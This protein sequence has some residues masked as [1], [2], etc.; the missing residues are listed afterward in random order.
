[1]KSW[2]ADRRERVL[3]RLAGLAGLLSTGLWFASMV[4]GHIVSGTRS[5]GVSDASVLT[6]LHDE[7]GRQLLSSVTGAAHYV[8]VVPLGLFLVAALRRRASGQG[9]RLLLLAGAPA[10]A[11]LALA[12]HFEV[13]T[14]SSMFLASGPR[15]T[16]RA[17]RL[18]AGSATLGGLRV[19][20]TAA[21]IVFSC[22]IAGVSLKAMDCGLVTRQLGYFGVGTAIALITLPPAGDALLIGFLLAVCSLALGNWPGGRP[23]AWDAGITSP[24]R[25]RAIGSAR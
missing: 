12:S 19:I 2:G 18:L 9:L 11:A 17:H 5:S 23:P 24:W 1:M 13:Q 21:R 4:L 3:G 14:I 22:W 7:P 16:A 20:A 8:L 15:T 25:G 10:L 6:T